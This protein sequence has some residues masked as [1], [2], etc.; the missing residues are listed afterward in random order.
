MPLCFHLVK[1]TSVH[2]ANV[3]SCRDTIPHD[4]NAKI[5]LSSFAAILRD[6]PAPVFVDSFLR[7]LDPGLDGKLLMFERWLMRNQLRIV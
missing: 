3:Y 4:T 5:A 6:H 2:P 1:V 7:H